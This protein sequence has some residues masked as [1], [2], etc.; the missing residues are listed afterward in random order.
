MD[1]VAG[2]PAR[3][4]EPSVEKLSMIKFRQRRSPAI[5]QVGASLVAS[6][7][8]FGLPSTAHAA[9]TKIANDGT[10]LPAGAALGSGPTDWACTRDDATGLVYEV[11]TPANANAVYTLAA[12]N[13]SYPQ[14]VNAARLCGFSDWRL[15]SLEELHELVIRTAP[16][17][18]GDR[19]SS[20]FFPNTGTQFYWSAT[21]RLESPAEGTGV[22]FCRGAWSNQRQIATNSASTRLVR[23]GKLFDSLPATATAC[24][25]VTFDF[26]VDAIPRVGHA[27]VSFCGAP[28][29]QARVY[30]GATLLCSSPI[31]AA[32]VGSC[33]ATLGL[34]GPRELRVEYY[35][36]T[37]QCTSSVR[38]YTRN[39]FATITVQSG[40]SCAA[41]TY[42]SSAA[43]PNACQVCT[44]CAAGT[45][46]TAPNANACTACAAG[47]FA[48][49]GQSSC[50]AHTTCAP[51][52]RVSSAG[53]SS[54]DRT[55]QACGAG[56][57]SSASNQPSCAPFTTCGV[58]AFVSVP[59]TSTTDQTC[60]ACEPGTY[61]PANGAGSC[62]AHRDCPAGTRID[63]A[64]NA[65][66]D[67]TCVACAQGTF[68]S[69]PNQESC[70][71]F[72][73]C[74]P[75]AF[76]SSPGTSTTDQECSLCQPGTYTPESGAGSCVSYRDCPAG[77]RIDGAGNATTDRSCVA[78]AQ[79]TFTTTMN[80]AS[81]T[82]FTTCAAGTSESTPGT[83]TKDR[84]CA[85]ETQ[86][87]DAGNVV[88][89]AGTVGP[90]A[91][92]DAGG[93]GTGNGPGGKE[94]VT[95]AG[96]SADGAVV[97]AEEGGCSTSHS[98]AGRSGVA[99][100]LLVAAAVRYARRRQCPR[101]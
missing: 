25:P 74:E 3:V 76:V 73:A 62:V 14:A 10:A 44:A 84:T 89:D 63:D 18:C 30:D 17:I 83:D 65:S 5:R 40:P 4:C 82:P 41:G 81:C 57:F 13:V 67:R 88:P 92:V 72:T 2:L 36:V 71:A 69:A 24:Q 11:K 19:V 31:D 66:T 21:K 37:E 28:Q 50:T 94:S 43:T 58:G 75:G 32:G 55:C 52:S 54:A 78:C 95:D 6:V 39:A 61:N 42:V 49:A 1:A 59:G 100:W 7:A 33:T 29:L 8:F 35:A 9:Y 45:V 64:G 48:S 77:T 80:E 86:V 51:G 79:G 98:R 46:S 60:S 87:P 93:D 70:S 85:E 12:A 34:A 38:G 23:G 15:P 26:A 22:E 20:V 101:A 27:F 68:T 96:A 90:G 97:E 47:T 99:A 53:S 91:G 16:E 56:T